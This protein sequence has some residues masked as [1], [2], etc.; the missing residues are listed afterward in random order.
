MKLTYKNLIFIILISIF[1]IKVSAQQVSTLY[2][3]ENVPIRHNLNPAFQPTTRY[4]L[5]LPI[6]GFTQFGF[7]NNSVTLKDIIYN[8]N[9]QTITF[10][11]PNGDINKF[12]NTLKPTSVLRTD[13]QTNLLSFG[14]KTKEAFW[15]LS[16]SEKIDGMVS[17][18]KDFFKISLFGTTSINNNSFNLSTLQSDF[19]AYTEAAFGYS[20][21]LDENLTVGIK[22]K[23][24]YGNANFSNTNEYLNLNAGIEK[25]T[26]NGSGSANVS[27]P[28][29]LQ[30][31]NNFQSISIQAPAN[32]A[33]WLKPSGL[34]SGIDLGIDYRVNDRIR[35]SAAITDL[36]F[37]RWYKNVQNI[38]YA[39]NY[40]F[41][42][43]GQINSN[44]SST[45]L[46]NLYTRFI[47]RNALVDSLTTAL[48]S[49]CRLNNTTNAYTTGT[50]A[51]LN[52]GFEYN[53][54]DDLV[55]FGL[56]SHAQ[57]FKKTITE[58]LTASVNL[59]PSK[60]FNAS[61][62][63]SLL[64][65]RMGSIGAGIGLKTGI[66]H[67]LLAA[68][69]I[70]FQKSTFLLS[71]FG[72]NYPAINLPLPYNSKNFNLALGMNLVFD[73]LSHKEKNKADQMDGLKNNT[74]GNE[75]MNL[76]SEKRNSRS[77]NKQNSLHRNMS[78]QNC[79]CDSN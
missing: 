48:K 25:W 21:K 27:S 53:I 47:T 1:Q 36:G 73:W 74:S 54:L 29:Q 79:N 56:L 49:A 44:M 11:N 78:N 15:S 18:P 2:F 77:L 62:S 24:L 14:F 66:F 72:A 75:Y 41:D 5:S 70:P 45:N 8:Y 16:I 50:T 4:Y 60:W 43:I 23:L 76:N 17:I 65:G 31:A 51:K 32:T 55:G 71:D 3:M 42:G 63:Y 38:N 64:D 22:L 33:D 37:I 52:L 20:Q 58:E 12:Y 26:L 61:L 68:D 69:Y 6:I 46:R 67:W 9:G 13:L 39:A 7:G 28:S 34:G 19:S 30:V 59:R 40:T 10:L 35:L 57:F